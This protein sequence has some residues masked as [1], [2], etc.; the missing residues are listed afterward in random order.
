M[1]N[2]LR[3]QK[4]STLSISDKSFYLLLGS[5]FLLT[6]GN[7]LYELLLPLIIYELTHSSVAM[8]SMRTAE[9][10]PNLIFGIFIGVIVDRVNKK[11]WVLWM[12]G[13]QAVLLVFMASLV[14]MDSNWLILFYIIGFL[15]MTFNYGYFNA[16]ISLTKLTVP[17]DKMTSANAKF[18]FIETFIGI[19]GPGFAGIVLLFSYYNGLMITAIGYMISFLCLSQLRVQTPAISITKK[20]FFSELKEGWF[21]YFCNKALFLM[22]IFIMLL[23]CSATVVLTTVIFFAKDD[24]HLSS[25][26]VAYIMSA[27]GAGGLFASFIVS[28]LRLRFGLGFLFGISIV[29]NAASFILL[30]FSHNA[31]MLLT[32]LLIYGFAGTIYG[33]MAY[34][35]RLE[36]TPTKLMGRISGITGTIFRL[37]M[38]VTMYFSGYMVLW[39]GSTSVFLSAFT[40]NIV[41]FLI[42]YKTS[43]WNVR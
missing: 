41:I 7:K 17:A 19:M 21:V 6:I 24:L 18:S 1:A 16:Q 4:L 25:A 34:S 2:T 22:S 5:T 30:Y 15:L 28:K 42:Y 12:I 26:A 14:R 37:G 27:G 23:N 10:L 36:Q 8:T 35:F 43:L 29:L 31:F 33:V 38:P 9:L 11:K 3:K 13:T 40:F 20:S 39:W 32:S